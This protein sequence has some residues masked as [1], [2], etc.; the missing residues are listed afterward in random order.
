MMVL[1]SILLAAALALSSTTVLGQ[2]NHGK[3]E[4][5]CEKEHAV[6]GIS[7]KCHCKKGYKMT[8]KSGVKMCEVNKFHLPVKCEPGHECGK[9]CFDGLDNDGDGLTDCDDP[10]CQFDKRARKHCKGKGVHY[11]KE[12]CA[13]L[14]PGNKAMD[15][16]RRIERYCCPGKD[17]EKVPDSCPKRCSRVFVPFWTA[18]QT[19]FHAVSTP[20]DD[21][22]LAGLDALY[23]MCQRAETP[24]GEEEDETV[25]DYGGYLSMM[26]DCSDMNQNEL[27]QVL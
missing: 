4:I 8:K 1:K 2:K 23:P 20:S 13:L 27:S 26:L 25:C 7:G 9:E 17:C 12:E 11:G 5:E 18:C 10:D 21:S 6:L 15:E 19:A 3:Q 22:H 14:S 16:L 24:N